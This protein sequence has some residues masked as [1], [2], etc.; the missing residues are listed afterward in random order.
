MKDLRSAFLHCD[1]QL[2]LQVKTE[3]FSIIASADEKTIVPKPNASL[4]L[5]ILLLAAY[6]LSSSL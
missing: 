4:A 6:L 5:G 2:I 3:S 1:R